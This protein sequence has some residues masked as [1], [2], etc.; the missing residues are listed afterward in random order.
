MENGPWE[1]KKDLDSWENRERLVN[2]LKDLHCSFCGSLHPDIFLSLIEKG[3]EVTPTDKCYKTYIN[4]KGKETKFYF[5]HLSKKHILKFIDLLNNGIMKLAYPGHFY[6]KPFF[7]VVNSAPPFSFGAIVKVEKKIEDGQVITLIDPIYTF[8]LN[9]IKKHPEIIYQIDPRK[10]EEL[11]AAA[12]DK[13]GFDEVI[14]T[15]RSGD[16]GRDVIAIKKGIGSIK[17]IE[18]IKAYNP[19]HLVKS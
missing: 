2:G 9:E 14:L 8:L 16:L 7:L 12:Y 6:E 3:A 1:K 13:A 11:I 18:Q 4:Y 19:G 10:W 5:Q 17:F 15:P